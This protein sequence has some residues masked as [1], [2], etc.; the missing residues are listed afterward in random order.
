MFFITTEI[1]LVSP[2]HQLTEPVLIEINCALKSG[3]G[4]QA[5][6][7]S[8]PAPT[9]DPSEW[10]LMV[11]APVASVDVNAGGTVPI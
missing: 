2:A 5:I 4:T 7:R 3:G 8:N 1:V 10:N 11:N 6:E 9:T